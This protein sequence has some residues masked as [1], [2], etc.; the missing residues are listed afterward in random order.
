MKSSSKASERLIPLSLLAFIIAVAVILWFLDLVNQWRV[1]AFLLSAALTAFAMLV[2]FYRVEITKEYPMKLSK[3]WLSTGYAAIALLVILSIAVSLPGAPALKPNV[4][5]VLYEGEITATRSGFGFNATNLTSP[6][7]TLNFTVDDV[8]NMTVYNVGQEPHNWVI[9]SANQT[10]A[11]VLFNAQVATVDFP[12]QHGDHGSA[13]FTVTQAG[14]FFYICQV[15]GHL[16]ED[17]MWGKVI[18]NP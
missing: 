17:G 12:L 13:I 4:T 15:P 7:P 14:N 18:V 16:T 2:Y 1:F 10:S 9:V 11:P 3:S 5:M 8:V 6:G